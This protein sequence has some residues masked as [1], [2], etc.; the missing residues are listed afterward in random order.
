MVVVCSSFSWHNLRAQGGLTYVMTDL[1]PTEGEW[2]SQPKS[3]GKE[4]A[5]TETANRAP[6]A[7]CCWSWLERSVLSLPLSWA[8]CLPAVCSLLPHYLFPCL[9]FPQCMVVRGRKRSSGALVFSEVKKK[10]RRWGLLPQYCNE[11]KTENC[12][13]NNHRGPDQLVQLWLL[14]LKGQCVKKKTAGASLLWKQWWLNH[15]CVPESEVIWKRLVETVLLRSQSRI[16]H[17][18]SVKGV[19]SGEW[20]NFMYLVMKLSCW[21]PRII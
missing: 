12:W 7:K 5:W 6:S 16:S 20:T 3:L 21:P 9:C 13:F 1:S 2:T 17:F 8:F 10:S 14:L 15:S 18:F 4:N 19:R 11:V